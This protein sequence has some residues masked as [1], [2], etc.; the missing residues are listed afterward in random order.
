MHE[1]RRSFR[2]G[3]KDIAPILL[4]VMPFAMISGIT[5]V[6]VGISQP[7]AMAMSVFIFAGASQLA[8]YQLIAAGALPLVVIYTAL[9]VNLRFVVYSASIAPYF[10][11]LST[12]WKWLYAYMLT[13]QGYAISLIR[14][15]EDET[16]SRAWYYLGASLPVWFVWQVFSAAGIFVGS[17]V[18]AHWGLD[19]AIP[20][21]FMAVLVRSLEN[22]AAVIAAVV[23]GVGAAA[24]YHLPL[25]LGLV[26][27]VA[28]GILA[29]FAVDVASRPRRARKGER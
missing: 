14:F 11:S 24:G 16:V 20:L 27:G 25:N 19:F 28:A 18:P 1:N 7:M 13:D 5:A 22:R 17:A 21:T 10:Q 2:E 15:R 8:A 12:P 29:G 9:V 3:A 26:L 23:G 6:N 4:G